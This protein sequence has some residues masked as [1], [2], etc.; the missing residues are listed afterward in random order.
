MGF[1]ERDF[2]LPYGKQF[3]P[4]HRT[5]R[6]KLR[7]IVKRPPDVFRSHV[8]AADH[9]GRFTVLYFRYNLVFL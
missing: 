7:A 5:R 4:L 2:R 3:N 1:L 8:G 9:W 6:W